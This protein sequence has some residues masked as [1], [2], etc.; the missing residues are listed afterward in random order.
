MLRSS[1]GEVAWDYASIARS[2]GN[3]GNRFHF[4]HVFLF[5]VHVCRCCHVRLGCC[6]PRVPELR[7]LRGAIPKSRLIN[8]AQATGPVRWAL[9]CVR[10][11]YKSERQRD[12]SGHCVSKEM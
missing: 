5:R 11:V 8:S 10:W 2:Y 12:R 4:F 7:G 9:K 6:K 3:L 1:S